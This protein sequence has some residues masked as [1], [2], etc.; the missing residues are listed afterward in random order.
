MDGD[1]DIDIVS[2]S[3]T[4]STIAWYE[5]NGQATS[6]SSGVDIVTNASGAESVYVAAVDSGNRLNRSTV[7]NHKFAKHVVR[8][9]HDAI[10]DFFCTSNARGAKI[11]FLSSDPKL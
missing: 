8:E 5:N 4:D 7:W 10:F 3:Y 1:G 9:V 11:D 2:A 6:W